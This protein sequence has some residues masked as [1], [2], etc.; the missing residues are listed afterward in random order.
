MV[1]AVVDGATPNALGLLPVVG[2]EGRAG[3]VLVGPEA[4]CCK[5]RL[6]RGGGVGTCVTTS[7]ELLECWPNVNRI[8]RVGNDFDGD[9]MVDAS[10]L[11]VFSAATRACLPLCSPSALVDAA[12]AVA[13]A[14]AAVVAVA[15]PRAKRRGLGSGWRCDACIV[16]LTEGSECNCWYVQVQAK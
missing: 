4:P 8:P 11:L 1:V 3:A 12:A 15:A 6:R 5:L 13:A 10:S 14:A 9:A 16:L 7:R 2:G